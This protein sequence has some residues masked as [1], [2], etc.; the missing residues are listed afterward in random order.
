MLIAHIADLHISGKNYDRAKDALDQV[1][2]YVYDE[3]I[4]VVVFSGDVF[5]KGNIA[6]R[7]KS[8]GDLQLLFSKAIE[9][10]KKVYVL[11]GNHDQTSGAS[12]LEFVRG[13]ENVDLI[14]QVCSK[15]YKGVDFLFIPWV[16][17][18]SEMTRHYVRENINMFPK[19]DNP[20]L[21][22]GHLNIV[23]SKVGEYVV[24][25]DSGHSFT[26]NELAKVGSD[27]MSFGHIHKRDDFYCGA[28]FQNSFSEEGNPQG[29]E[30][31]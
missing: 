24:S 14:S 15:H 21:L 30:V 20:R 11:E 19:T 7:Y 12:A 31:F 23:G 27:I 9:S 5:D 2:D 28:L 26:K 16:K 22:F 13:Y 4:E 17:E 1:A 10:M 8:V 25:D 6:D 18:M 29:F 3:G